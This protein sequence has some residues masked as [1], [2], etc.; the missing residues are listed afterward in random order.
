MSFSL[1]INLRNVESHFLLIA[2]NNLI[3]CEGLEKVNGLNHEIN[4]IEEFI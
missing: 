2:K 4:W 3:K 1:I